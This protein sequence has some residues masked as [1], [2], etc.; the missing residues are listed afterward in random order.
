MSPDMQRPWWRLSS[1]WIFIGFLGIA[2]F[3]LISEHRA[4]TL[5]LLPYLLLLLCP[6]MHLFHGGHG[7]HAGHRREDDGDAK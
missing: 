3:F 1:R 6:L 5:G 2:A 4:H 7:N